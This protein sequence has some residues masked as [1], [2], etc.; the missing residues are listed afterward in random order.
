M[1]PIDTKVQQGLPQSASGFESRPTLNSP[2]FD[3][4]SLS[5]YETQAVA[6]YPIAPNQ[7]LLVRGTDGRVIPSEPSL[8]F[9]NEVQSAANIGTLIV[10]ATISAPG[11]VFENTSASGVVHLRALQLDCGHLVVATQDATGAQVNINQYS[12]RGDFIRT[13]QLETAA[14]TNIQIIKANAIDQFWVVWSISGTSTIR[15]ALLRRNLTSVASTFTL[16]TQAAS[17]LSHSWHAACLSDDSLAL[18]YNRSGGSGELL[19]Y[20]NAGA[21]IGSP[22]SF[23]ATIAATP[24]I[25]IVP[26]TLASGRPSF[27]ITWTNASNTLYARYEILSGAISILGGTGTVTG[28][29]GSL[30]VGNAQNRIIQLDNGNIAV[31]FS[32]SADSRSDVQIVNGETG[33]AV[34]QVD[35]TSGVDTGRVVGMC[36]AHP[37]TFFCVS[38]SGVNFIIASIT[39][40]GVY[41]RSLTASSSI[42]ITTPVTNNIFCVRLGYLVFVG[43]THNNG[44]NFASAYTTFHSGT[45]SVWQSPTAVQT[46]TT[47]NCGACFATFAHNGGSVFFYSGLASVGTGQIVV[48]RVQQTTYIGVSLSAARAGETVRIG[49][50]GTFEL[51]PNPDIG[52]W[53]TPYPSPTQIR[54]AGPGGQYIIHGGRFVTLLGHTTQN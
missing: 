45:C 32:N 34:V 41:A 49:T 6:G 18:A 8:S 9:P 44:T 26:I 27:A 14:S 50:R 53:P 54:Q 51:R 19:A 30:L 11:G 16:T 12:P 23:A 40:A 36:S 25:G 15:A 28:S 13:V 5:Y 3:S 31:Q 47:T 48:R 43:F 17:T 22:V 10:N 2:P 33:A 29:N 1:F 4:Q 46:S 42:S 37:G 52:Q 21:A 38:P 39:N 7:L 35:L 20:T 24:G